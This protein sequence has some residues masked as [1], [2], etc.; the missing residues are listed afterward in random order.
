VPVFLRLDRQAGAELSGH[1]ARAAAVSP[2]G[3]ALRNPI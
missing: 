2:T 1:V 3:K